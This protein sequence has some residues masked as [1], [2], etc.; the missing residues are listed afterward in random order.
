MKLH[1]TPQ[2]NGVAERKHRHLL[3]VTRSLMF[4][5]SVPKQHWPKALLRACH[6]INRMLP[7]ASFDNTMPFQ[8]IFSDKPYSLLNPK[9][10]A[11]YVLYT[12]I[13]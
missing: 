6:L 7:S 10:L 5:M 3:E 12:F 4:Y 9:P 8:L 2:Q 11:V 1:V 13:P